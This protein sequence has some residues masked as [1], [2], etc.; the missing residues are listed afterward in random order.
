MTKNASFFYMCTNISFLNQI[1]FSQKI[2]KYIFKG[3][4]LVR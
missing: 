2:Y 1:F 4:N 3:K